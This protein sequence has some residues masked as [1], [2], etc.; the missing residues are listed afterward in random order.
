MKMRSA[1][2]GTAMGAVALLVTTLSA[3]A[4]SGAGGTGEKADDADFSR[5]EENL[6]G[7]YEGTYKEPEGPEVEAP[8]GKD[9]WVVSVGMGIEYSVRVADA[10]NQAA[11]ELGWDVHVFDA[12][13]DPNQMLTGIQQ[14]V[15]A[16]ADGI[17]VQAIDCA[18]VKNAAQQAADADIPVIGIESADCDP[19]V[20]AHV[21]GYSGKASFEDWVRDFGRAQAAWVIGTTDGQANAVINTGTDT[22]TTRLAS[23]GIRAEFEECPT[24]EIVDDATWVAADLGPSLQEKI[25]QTMVKHPDANAFIPSYDAIMTQSG[26]AQALKSTG[27]IDQLSVAGGE[28]TIAGIEQIRSGDGMEMCAGQSGEWE[29]YSAIDALVRLFLDR[30][31]AEVDTGNGIQVC[32][33]DHNL[34]PEGE[35]Y[36]PPVDFVASYNQLWGRG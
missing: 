34:P 29:T 16:D 4:G 8:E 18:T 15:V 26:G 28:G 10:A 12:K 20:Y 22:V 27:R 13:F 24:C 7:W 33:E 19:G 25:Q 2:R 6:E 5:Y 36:T 3:C 32:D 9:I 35:P 17:I 1:S 23:E 30:D 11:D 21:V 31:P 14:A